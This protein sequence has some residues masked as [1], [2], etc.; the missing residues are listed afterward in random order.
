M[1]FETLRFDMDWRFETM[2]INILFDIMSDNDSIFNISFDIFDM[3]VSL[4]Y[5]LV[6][7]WWKL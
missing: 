4:M 7:F 1:E 6:P 2:D 5:G 3:S